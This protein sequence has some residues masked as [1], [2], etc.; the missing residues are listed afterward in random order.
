MNRKTLSIRMDYP[1]EDEKW[2]EVFHAIVNE[3][4]EHDRTM[5][6]IPRSTKTNA[7]AYPPIKYED[8]ELPPPPALSKYFKGSF[9][10]RNENRRAKWYFNITTDAK[11]FTEWKT[12]ELIEA[13]G[14]YDGFIKEDR[15]GDVPSGAAGWLIRL[16]PGW[17]WIE[18]LPDE[19]EPKIA[20]TTGRKIPIEIQKR[21]KSARVT[22]AQY[23]AYV[24]EH[25]KTAPTR[26]RIQWETIPWTEQTV[27]TT[28]VEITTSNKERKIVQ[29]AL[30][31]LNKTGD[32]GIL[33]FISLGTMDTDKDLRA[34]T[35]LK[36][37]D[38]VNKTAFIPVT[39]ISD[40]IM[41]SK[42]EAGL[43]YLGITEDMMT[44]ETPEDEHEDSEQ[45]TPDHENAK[46]MEINETDHKSDK[47]SPP[48]SQREKLREY[49]EKHPE[50]MTLKE[51]ILLQQVAGKGVF[52]EVARTFDT[53]ETGRWNLMVHK[54]NLAWARQWI[55]DF[56]PIAITRC[57]RYTEDTRVMRDD[58]ISQRIEERMHTIAGNIA[59]LPLNHSFQ[60]PT[61]DIHNAAMLP[62]DAPTG[63]RNDAAAEH[64]ER[65]H[66]DSTARQFQELERRVQASED[67]MKKLRDNNKNSDTEEST[68]GAACTPTL[69]RVTQ[70]EKQVE[71][72]TKKLESSTAP[73][74]PT[75]ATDLEALVEGKVKESMGKL[76]ADVVSNINTKF[77]EKMA[78]DN[79]AQKTRVDA[80]D[81]MNKAWE[82]AQDTKWELWKTQYETGM[83]TWRDNFLQE[84][85]KLYLETSGAAPTGQSKET[86]QKKAAPNM[87]TEPAEVQETLRRSSSKDVDMLDD[88]PPPAKQHKV[89]ST[90][91]PTRDKT[92]PR[93]KSLDKE[94]SAEREDED[95][96]E[97][98]LGEQIEE[99][100]EPHIDHHR[101]NRALAGIKQFFSPTNRTPTNAHPANTP[102]NNEETSSGS[103]AGGSL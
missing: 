34:F 36:Q 11:S 44:T 70:L 20:S 89:A 56:L 29:E 76:E 94:N 79:R 78:A 49:Y 57:E 19:L 5:E 45:R 96:E 17:T 40:T 102:F 82:K 16:H 80:I 53:A 7:F 33:K 21:N 2:G 95:M 74:E 31:D 50:K 3:L 37:K 101:K 93:E 83:N 30:L 69:D 85:K 54:S 15:I 48:L 90:S 67:A 4:Y 86:I 84:M 1:Q 59:Q 60:A 97:I 87:I 32:L 65:R 103:P 98:S 24:K 39:G 62:T 100:G 91:S 73:A 51:F 66:G 43:E 22:R 99:A 27:T 14:E 8:N 81:T 77:D 58:Q 72:L 68:A 25:N 61:A 64:L 35:L 71:T 52:N 9:Y 75:P 38:Y 55:D 92:F 12:K 26:E 18:G 46:D 47:R 28:I 13:L 63:L 10:G 41:N 6:I 42:C 88:P 23:A